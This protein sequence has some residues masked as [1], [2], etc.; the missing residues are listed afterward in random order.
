MGVIRDV[1]LRRAARQ[2]VAEDASTAPASRVGP[3]GGS[4]I[5]CEPQV[6]PA[7]DRPCLVFSPWPADLPGL[8]P[9]HVGPFSSCAICEAGT[10]ARFGGTPLCF[11]C[12]L[13]VSPERLAH[14]MAGEIVEVVGLEKGD[15]QP[16][17]KA[18]A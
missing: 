9:R 15:R 10:W 8:G 11:A 4:Q 12:A 16:D 7:P 1:L 17:H 3:P 14:L 18:Q 13:T 5:P 6:L 2:L